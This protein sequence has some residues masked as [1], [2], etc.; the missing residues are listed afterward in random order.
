MKPPWGLGGVLADGSPEQ[1]ELRLSG[2][3]E[4][5]PLTPPLSKGEILALTPPLSKGGLA[6]WIN[7]Q[8]INVS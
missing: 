4:I 7:C 2:V 3:T 8:R 1:T 5:A 6:G